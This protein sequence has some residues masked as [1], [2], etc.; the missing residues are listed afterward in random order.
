[1]KAVDRQQQ[2]GQVLVLFAFVLVALV[3]LGGL[4]FTGA[5]G[6]VM[7][8]QLQNASDAA[9]LAAANLLIIEGGCTAGS[10]GGPPRNVV[11]NAARAAATTN[12]P[13]LST[14][15]ISVSCP[16]GY[17]NFAV[18]VVL[19]GT[20]PSFFGAGGQPV[21]AASTAVNGQI[22]TSVYSVALL[23]P[24]NLSWPSQRNGCASF[25]M[26][27][28]ITATVEGSVMV[29]STCRLAD[30]NAG[31]LN[32]NGSSAAL[33]MAS[34]AEILI[35][36]EYNRRVTVNGMAPIENYSPPMVDP[37]SAIIDPPTLLG[38][39]LN[40]TLPAR[41]LATVCTGSNR[42]PCILTPGVYTG[43]FNPT[44]AHGSLFVL[45]PGVYVMRGGGFTSGSA[46]F[47]TV[48][49]PTTVADVDVRLRYANVAAAEAR[50]STDCPADPAVGRCG[51]MI[52]NA[53]SCD[54][55]NWSLPN[56]DR[57]S[58]GSNGSVRLRGYNPRGDPDGGTFISVANIVVWQARLPAPSAAREQPQ[59]HLGGGGSVTLS[60]TIY[61]P[62][63][64]V[65]FGGSSSGTGGLT[66]SALVQFIVW[67]LQLQ[68]NNNFYFEYRGR[69]F[70]FPSSY[71]LI[72]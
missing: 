47:Y 56:A 72:D 68:G 52:Y 59:L 1:V 57:I 14:D 29:N 17:N 18:R 65:M 38:A 45:R 33:T 11:D 39:N 8:R 44:G 49:P 71:G 34:G 9:A 21:S 4:L 51:V 6:L 60:G 55:C 20:S 2:E 69:Y 46:S 3:A 54:A 12:L 70:A 22:G 26:G 36:G 13:D 43:G 5:Q 30:N 42:N 35:G 61:A 53:P 28:G 67:D 16:T 41:T 50:W 10:E 27:G 64:Q 37:L 24:A 58:W 62:G 63:A 48:P 66:D 31:A 15:N 40:A 7:R 32:T 19:T 23:N 25:L